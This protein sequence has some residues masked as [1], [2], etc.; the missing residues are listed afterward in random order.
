MSKS[1][2]R[3]QALDPAHKLSGLLIP[4]FA[5]RRQGDLG[6]GDTQC[7]MDSVDFLASLS[8]TVLQ[9]LPINET[10]AD[11]SPYN[12]LSATALDPVYLTMSPLMVPGLSEKMLAELAPASLVAELEEGPVDY[13]RVKKLKLDLLHAAFTAFTG[14]AAG[15][16]GSEALAAFKKQP[17][18]KNYSIF[19][20]FMDE[21]GGSAVWTEWKPEHR[22][23]R[24][25][26]Q[27]LETDLKS[28][29]KIKQRMDFYEYVQWVAY[30]QWHQVRLYADRCGVALMGD[31][32]FGVSRYSADVFGFRELFDLENSGGAPPESFF[33]TDKFTA[34]WGQNWGIPLYNWDEHR[35]TKFAFW[36]ERVR[37]TTEI[38]HY[39]RIDHV[40]GF[41]RVYAFPWIPERNSEFVDLSEEEA[42]ALAGGRLPRFLPRADEP[43]E[44]A[45]LNL[46]EGTA[47]LDVI[48]DAAGEAG[49][50]AEDLGMVP[51]YVRPRLQEMRIPG[52]I[53]P[54]FERQEDD[55]ER[56]FRSPDT[57]EAVSLVTLGTHDH[58][59]IASYYE[60]LS[61][62]WRGEDGH[63][64]W[65]EVSRLMR[66]LGLS[67]EEA[68]E[69]FSDD[70]HRRLLQVVLTSPSWLAVLMI[71][72]LLG[73]SQRFNEPGLAGDS[74][75][76]QRLE[77]PLAMYKK[78]P[79]YLELFTWLRKVVRESGREARPT[80]PGTSK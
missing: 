30:Q 31:I 72:D 12:A 9:L 40:L 29:G 58:E 41:F 78:D 74:N 23:R 59:P 45:L 69:H 8:M 43:E 16:A 38:F 50:V 26:E 63:E 73:T 62:W 44:N 76:S 27:I 55:P 52:F 66:F 11:N 36:R 35:K 2:F 64:G 47:L 71:S 80:I 14:G 3:T 42:R 25:L 53:I 70:L 21:N 32:P 5:M 19:R 13:A 75:W 48:L 77:K 22:D 4:V 24:H 33:Q 65:L 1:K 7:V 67:P 54:I 6:V 28:G 37:Q 10:G 56:N 79:H 46:K 39:F 20:A 18:L 61:K 60:R 17:W 49:V 34:V 51:G 68:P 57:Y 15:E